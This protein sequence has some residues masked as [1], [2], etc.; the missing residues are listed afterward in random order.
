M[1]YRCGNGEAT[2]LSFAKT[3]GPLG[4]MLLAAS[5]AALCGL[6][7]M[8]QRYFPPVSPD[9]PEQI[10]EIAMPCRSFTKRQAGPA[11]ILEQTVE[12]L[13]AYFAGDLRQFSIPL[14]PAGTPFQR[15]VWK[16]LLAIPHGQTR[17][18]SEIAA[19]IGCP[20]APRAVGA[21]I[22]KNP[23]SIIIPCHRVLGKSGSLTGYA[24]GTDKKRFLL[25]LERE[26]RSL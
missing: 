1:N 11:S 7:F 19:G 4:E 17:S 5:D 10:R 3:R 26:P 20:G 16:Q 13:G 15:K 2:P 23:V 8:G 9:H 12:E 18:Y 24:G 6:W 25:A 22:G 21:A 14:E